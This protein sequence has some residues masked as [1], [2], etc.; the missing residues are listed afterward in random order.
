M[1]SVF[2]CIQMENSNTHRVN[3]VQLVNSVLEVR[4]GRV[5]GSRSVFSSCA[6]RSR[7]CSIVEGPEFDSRIVCEGGERVMSWRNY[8]FNVCIGMACGSIVGLFA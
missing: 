8:G 5:R 7:R 2:R 4:E 3:T 1:T 6:L